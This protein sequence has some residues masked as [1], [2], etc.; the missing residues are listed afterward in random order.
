MQKYIYRN[1]GYI[2]ST[3]QASNSQDGLDKSNRHVT[4]KQKTVLPSQVDPI[5]HKPKQKTHSLIDVFHVK[6]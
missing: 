6:I 1:T 2:T 4:R 5:K 3:E